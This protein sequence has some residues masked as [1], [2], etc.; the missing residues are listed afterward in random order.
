MNGFEKKRNKKIFEILIVLKVIYIFL[1]VVALISS[2]DCKFK[3]NIS[4]LVLYSIIALVIIAIYFVWIY[5]NTN[6]NNK[7]I[8]KRSKY[9]EIILLLVIFIIVLSG[10]GFYQSPY[11][12]ISIFIILIG[13]IQFGSTY[14]LLTAISCGI[15]IVVIDCISINNKQLL[16]LYFQR[17][18]VL[19]GALLV[20]AYILG[21]YVNIEKEHSEE[22]KGLISLDGLTGLYN[23]RYFQE[24]LDNSIQ[25]SDNEGQTIS[26]LFMDIDYFKHFNDING[27]QSGDWV[28]KK[29]GSILKNSVRKN[30][31][32]AR[33]GGEE[34]AA[35]LVNTKEKEAID[36]GEKIRKNV[37]NAYFEGQDKQP[38]KNITISIGVSSY[39]DKA[40]NKYQLINTADDA[41]YRAKFFNKNRVEI[42]HNILDDLCSYINIDNEAIKSMKTFISMINLKDKYTY[43]HTERVVIYIRNFAKYLNLKEEEFINL[44]IGAYLHDIGKVDIP[45]AILNKKDKL[46]D[47][48]FELLKK[49]PQYGVDLIKDIKQFQSFMPLVKHHHERYDGKGYPD[50]LK[51]KEIPYLARILAIADSF[52]AMT[53]NRP[54]NMRKSHDEAIE[55]LRKNSGTQFDPIL[56]EKFISMI[57]VYKDKF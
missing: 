6:A 30:D 42:Y 55:E 39:P 45:E 37:E 10:T 8:M 56:V 18:I 9:I 14:S 19:I 53:S 17:E 13:A 47:E 46:N 23:H 4:T 57:K 44:N 26:L 1:G 41:L 21:M 25:S 38:N 35:I 12:F 20:T 33:Y 50:K 22:L 49:H 54:Y 5:N 40:K 32:V 36:I 48:E 52:D 29:I 31:I 43:A 3:F 24:H 28:L 16:N 51:G 11:K 34:F 7:K 27:H 15:I 2:I